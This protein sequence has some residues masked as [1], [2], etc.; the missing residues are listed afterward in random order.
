MQRRARASSSERCP[1]WR[2][3]ASTP[4]TRWPRPR[5]YT[6]RLLISADSADLA[7][8]WAELGHSVYC[9]VTGRSSALSLQAQA[10]LGRVWTTVG[11]PD[12]AVE[13][14]ADLA[15]RLPERT[16]DPTHRQVFNGRADYA[17]ALHRVSRCES[18]RTLLA[19]CCRAHD[20]VFGAGRPGWHQDAGSARCDDPRLPRLRRRPHAVFAEAV[21]HAVGA[22]DRRRSA[23][24]ERVP[25]GSGA[26]A[27]PDHE[28]RP[29]PAPI[30]PAR[31][32]SAVAAGRPGDSGSDAPARR[33]RRSRSAARSRSPARSRSREIFQ[34]AVEKVD[35]RRWTELILRA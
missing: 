11:D 34:N 15:R 23:A 19:D 16:S 30:E 5:R 8:A 9:T 13:V 29:D 14:Y 33:L 21:G 31:P 1:I 3:P 20:R 10:V 27:D 35:S 32:P 12:R 4:T 6:P 17:A 28:C 2:R 26:D 25:A 18:A 24:G 22:P 7:V